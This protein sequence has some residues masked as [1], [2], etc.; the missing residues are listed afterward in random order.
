MK[1]EVVAIEK[2]EV[3]DMSFWRQ[4]LLYRKLR[5]LLSSG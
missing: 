3:Y 2:K 4:M 5:I 1:M